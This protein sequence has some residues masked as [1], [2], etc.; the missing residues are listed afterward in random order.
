MSKMDDISRTKPRT[1]PTGGPNYGEE[2]P[3]VG[4]R[5]RLRRSVADSIRPECGKPLAHPLHAQALCTKVETRGS[6]L[7]F[8]PLENGIVDLL[9]R[10]F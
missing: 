10:C 8:E 2:V 5:L 7:I 9:L 6:N 3:E 4:L 1:P